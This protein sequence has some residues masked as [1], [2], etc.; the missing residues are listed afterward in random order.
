VT[1]DGQE[2]GDLRSCTG[3]FCLAMLRLDAIDKPLAAGEARPA[4]SLPEWLQLPGTPSSSGYLPARD[5]GTPPQFLLGTRRPAGPRDTS[6]TPICGWIM[7]G[8]P[9]IG[10]IAGSWDLILHYGASECRY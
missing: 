2:V 1:T 10:A 5:G 9:Q 4:P 3:E 7:N 6:S 8:H